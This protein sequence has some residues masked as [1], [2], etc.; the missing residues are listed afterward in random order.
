MDEQRRNLALARYREH[1]KR[2]DDISRRR[3]RRAGGPTLV[4]PRPAAVPVAAPAP[5][6]TPSVRDRRL[7]RSFAVAAERAREAGLT[8]RETEVLKL[9]TAGASN[10]QIAG[11]LGVSTETVKTHV[12]SMLV[13]LGVESRAQAVTVGFCRGLLVPVH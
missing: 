7:V 1:S 12:R 8:P 10:S 5:V 4:P 11:R 6:P 9:V 13:T 3:A 2:F